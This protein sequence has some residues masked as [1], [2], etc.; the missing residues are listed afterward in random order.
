MQKISGILPS[1]PRIESVD[2]E[3]SQPVRSG[4]PLFG[5]RSSAPILPQ[6]RVTLSR[7]MSSQSPL[8]DNTVNPVYSPSARDKEAMN[9]EIADR[10]AQNFFR[11]NDRPATFAAGVGSATLVGSQQASE[12][13]ARSP[14]QGQPTGP[15]TAATGARE[16]TDAQIVAEV[17]PLN[18]SG[19]ATW[20]ESVS[21]SLTDPYA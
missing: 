1:T 3:S 14:G 17:E 20:T 5:R 19:P 4:V 16:L 2:I 15:A 18:L 7:V 12:M 6:D 21:R 11:L 8:A 10:I 9:S 13:S